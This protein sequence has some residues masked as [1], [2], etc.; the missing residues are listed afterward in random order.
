MASINKVIIVGRLGQDPQVNYTQNSAMV[1]NL[2]VATDEGYTDRQSGQKVEKTEWHRIVVWGKPAEFCANYLGKGRLV[3]VEGKLQ[4]RKW[5]DQNGQDRYTTEIVAWS[6]QAL[7]KA[8]QQG[9]G[10][11]QG[12][13]QNQTYQ[14]QAGSQQQQAPQQGGQGRQPPYQTPSEDYGP[15][16]PSEPGQMDTVPF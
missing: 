11:Q 5:Q 15:A 10:Q 12:N 2:S 9:Q 4:T 6:I 14:S 3:Y 7:D 1:V 8:P 16:F 13:P